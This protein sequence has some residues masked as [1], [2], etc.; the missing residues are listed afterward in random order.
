MVGAGGIERDRARFEIN[1]DAAQSAN[2]NV[3]E[4]LLMI[5]QIVIE[6]SLGRSTASG[7]QA[8]R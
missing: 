8:S 4:R 6:Q 1:L 2:L 3:G 5:A 7:C